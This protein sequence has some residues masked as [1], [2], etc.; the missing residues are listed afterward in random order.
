MNNLLLFA[1]RFAEDFLQYFKEDLN[2]VY[3]AEDQTWL[4]DN[5]KEE[6][7]MSVESEAKEITPKSLAGV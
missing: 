4:V 1:V 2:K 6:V 3:P 7:A 5:L